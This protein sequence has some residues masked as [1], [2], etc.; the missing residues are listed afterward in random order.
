MANIY[1]IGAGL[2]GRTMALDL[3]KNHTVFLADNNVELLES[4]KNEDPTIHI[5]RLDVNKSNDL[6][7]FIQNA[8]VVLLA[9]P[10]FLGFECLKKIIISKKNVV[11]ISFSPENSMQLDSLAKDHN[12]TAIIDAGVAPGIP[13][14]ILG[15]HNISMKIESFEYFVGGLP[16]HP[17]EPFNYKAPFS[18]IDVIEEYTRPARM[19][20]DKKLIIKPALTDIESFKFKDV[21]LLEMF[22]TDG[23]RSILSTM[24]H[25]PNMREKTVRYPGHAKLIK[26]Y[27]E[28][29][30]F[31]PTNIDDTAKQLIK[32]WKLGFQEEEFTVMDIILKSSTQKI[33]YHLFDSYDRS[34]N[35]SSMSR[36][37]GYTATASINLLLNNKITKTG[38]LPPELIGSVDSCW[39]YVFNY[40]ADRKVHIKRI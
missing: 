23:L 12:V 35:T 30:K 38:V 28:S 36:T 13:N 27:I 17:K 29:G 24:S 10:G 1:Q 7:K 39:D 40:L 34:S 22:N 5:K 26:T 25:I 9:V 19:M 11:D 15:F 21:G 14:Y 33:H 8:D 2:V 16:K 3:S 32:E 6:I 20:I 4:I 37:T 31:S 18:P